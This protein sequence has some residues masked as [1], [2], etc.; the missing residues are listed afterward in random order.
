[1]QKRK[2][3]APL[4]PGDGVAAEARGIAAAVARDARR[5]RRRGVPAR[6]PTAREGATAAD[7]AAARKED[8]A[9]DGSV[10]RP[11]AG[12]GRGERAR[13]DVRG[14]QKAMT[15]R[16]LISTRSDVAVN[17]GLLVSKLHRQPYI[18]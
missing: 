11:T 4:D 17:P 1:M 13:G 8:T 14:R 18:N 9:A 12:A 7:D 3:R 15:T 10:A 6:G 16:Q 2:S 5:R